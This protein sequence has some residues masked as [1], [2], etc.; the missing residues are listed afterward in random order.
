MLPTEINGHSK[1]DFHV[2]KKETSESGICQSLNN[3]SMEF[4]VLYKSRNSKS[5]VLKPET[6]MFSEGLLTVSGCL[7]F[8]SWELR[9]RC[10][11]PGNNLDFSSMVSAL[12]N[13]PFHLD[14]PSF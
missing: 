7:F 2:F 9:C 14:K 8:G 1:V 3:P 4:S 10:G 13:S 11:P 6:T 12:Q 5:T